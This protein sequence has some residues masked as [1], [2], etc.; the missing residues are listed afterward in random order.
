[1][2]HINTLL[3]CIKCFNLHNG[4]G[5][6]S[7]SSH[8]KLSLSLN[9]QFAA[10]EREEVNHYFLV[11]VPKLSVQSNNW[12]TDNFEEWLRDYNERKPVQQRDS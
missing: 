10:L 5:K 8:P 6:C 9:R 4:V 3:N 2:I 1:M 11:K 12:V 7:P